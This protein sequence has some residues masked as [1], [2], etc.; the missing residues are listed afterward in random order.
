M[1]TAELA[2]LHEEHKGLLWVARE[3]LRELRVISSGYEL[4]PSFRWV[5]KVAKEKVNIL[6]YYD[7]AVRL[8]DVA[9][10]AILGEIYKRIA[11][12]EAQFTEIGLDFESLGK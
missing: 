6:S 11:E 3:A 7:T 12:I 9:R 8:N 2:A 10:E 1:T 5:G 4:S